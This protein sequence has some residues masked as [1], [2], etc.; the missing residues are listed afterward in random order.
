MK[1]CAYLRVSTGRQAERDLSIPDQQ[2]QIEIH[3]DKGRAELVRVLV[4]PGASAMDENRPVFQEMIDWVTGPDHPVDVIIV[5]SYKQGS[6]PMERI[7][8][9]ARY[10]VKLPGQPAVACRLFSY[11]SSI[12]CM[13]RGTSTRWGRGSCEGWSLDLGDT[14]RCQVARGLDSPGETSKMARELEFDRVRR[15][16][17][18]RRGDG[19][20]RK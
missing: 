17:I 3:C 20:N 14:I 9:I 2:K 10:Q 12:Q 8:A 13:G 5:H 7:P 4:E 18:S 16:P 11:C 15:T 1:V 19:A 6:T